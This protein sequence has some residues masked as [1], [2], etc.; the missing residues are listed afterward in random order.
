MSAPGQK[1]TYY[2]VC[3]DTG[4]S[5][6]ASPKRA[7]FPNTG[8][9]DRN[10]KMRVRVANG[11]HLKVEFI[12]TMIIKAKCDTT[13]SAKKFIILPIKSSLYVPGLHTTLISPRELFKLQGIS[14]AFN[15]ENCISLP[16]GH[17]IVFADSGSS[18][19]LQALEFDMQQVTRKQLDVLDAW[20]ISG[21]SPIGEIHILQAHSLQDKQA[22][23][24]LIH[25]RLLHI[26]YS[27]SLIHI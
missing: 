14:T 3:P 13:S 20:V 18:Y 26:S 7:L 2:N 15:A 10:P 12:G 17:K 21:N 23:S 1:F 4:A 22:Y 24:D 25:S 9:Q 16:N 27:L 6:S 8:I 11:C 5:R 19:S